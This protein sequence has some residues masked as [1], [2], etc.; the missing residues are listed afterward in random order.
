MYVPGIVLVLLFILFAKDIGARFDALPTW[1]VVIGIFVLAFCYPSTILWIGGFGLLA[2]LGWGVLAIINLPHHKVPGIAAAVMG[3]VTVIVVAAIIG[4]QIHNG[5]F[6]TVEQ[7]QVNRED[8]SGS[9]GLTSQQLIDQAN[10]ADAAAQRADPCITTADGCSTPA[11]PQ[12]KALIDTANQAD[13]AAASA[14]VTQE[15]PICVPSCSADET[16]LGRANPQGSGSPQ[17]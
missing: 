11:T 10:E 2:L 5:T 6:H 8:T 12:Q 16:E 1:F 14:R 9:E 13:E 7:P 3:V 17:Q 15:P 4:S